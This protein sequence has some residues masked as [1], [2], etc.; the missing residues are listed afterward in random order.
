MPVC[1]IA[2][3]RAAEIFPSNMQQI[4]KLNA[5]HSTTILKD[6]LDLYYTYIF[7]LN[8]FKN[9]KSTIIS[10]HDDSR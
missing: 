10:P 4:S 8:V 6:M 7:Q 3:A 5:R 2:T 1:F 9:V